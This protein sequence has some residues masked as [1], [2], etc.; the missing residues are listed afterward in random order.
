MLNGIYSTCSIFNHSPNSPIAAKSP[1]PDRYLG[2]PKSARIEDW[3]AAGQKVWPGEMS[4]SP[5]IRDRLSYPMFPPE[6]IEPS[7]H[8]REKR[9]PP[10]STVQSSL[11]HPKEPNPSQRY[12][13]GPRPPAQDLGK[14]Q[15]GKH[16]ANQLCATMCNPGQGLCTVNEEVLPQWAIFNYDLLQ[17]CYKRRFQIWGSYTTDSGYTNP[18][19]LERK[20][21]STKSTDNTSG[22]GLEPVFREGD[23]PR[24]RG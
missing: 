8:M 5:T 21:K 24:E 23:R 4:N 12:T 19:G 1:P 17:R 9:R 18:I 14:T 11:S 15:E 2:S 22:K 13:R 20:S 7:Y 10:C 3:H 16:Q 6:D